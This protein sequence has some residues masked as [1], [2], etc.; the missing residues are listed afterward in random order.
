MKKDKLTGSYNTVMTMYQCISN[1][2][3]QPIDMYIVI[4]DALIYS[5]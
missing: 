4:T 1:N 2:I 3:A 5:Q